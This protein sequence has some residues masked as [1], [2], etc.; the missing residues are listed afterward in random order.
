MGLTQEHVPKIKALI[1]TIT[2]A[3]ILLLAVVSDHGGAILILSVGALFF[4]LY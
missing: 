3:G 2:V 4:G 1:C